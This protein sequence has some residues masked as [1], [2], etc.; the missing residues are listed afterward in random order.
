[1]CRHA[2]V[3]ATLRP[4][5]VWIGNAA[6]PEYVEE[7]LEL[8]KSL[9]VNFLPKQLV[10]QDEL[11]D[12]LSR[13][14]VM[15]YTSRLEPFGYAPLEAS[16][17]ETPVVGIAEGGIRESIEPGINGSLIDTRDPIALGQCIMRYVDKLGL[18]RSEGSKAR[19][20]ILK[21]SQVEAAA[22]RLEMHLV[23]VLQA[24]GHAQVRA[25][26]L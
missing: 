11:V 25:P 13:A 8:A 23:E 12:P 17:C 7:M 24:K 22:D 6:I 4:R 20:H 26:R 14:A 10:G 21:K 15:V 1:L 19:D 18:S 16:A 5:L 3:D 9:G 2:T